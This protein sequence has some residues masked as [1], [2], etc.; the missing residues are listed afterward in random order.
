MG[1]RGTFAKGNK[2]AFTYKTI[3]K[4]DGIKVLKGIDGK[5][6]LPEES[7]SSNAYITLN[8]DGSIRQIREYNKDLTAKTDIEFSI[9]K[10]K[11]SLHAHDY[12]NGKRQNARELTNEEKNL[13]LKHFWGAK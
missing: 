11:I 3:G 8:Y 1:G 5:H 9:H 12:K 6:G 10:G 4:I 7:H 13:Y 2:V